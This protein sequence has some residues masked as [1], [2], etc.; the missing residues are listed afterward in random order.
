MV[1]VVFFESLQWIILTAAI[2]DVFNGTKMLYN[3]HKVG[4]H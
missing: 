2:L 4:L 1:S 3:L